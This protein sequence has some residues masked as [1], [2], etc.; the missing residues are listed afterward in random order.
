MIGE[1]KMKI[2]YV[3][4]ISNTINAFLIPH[5]KM[6]INQGHQVDIACNV[7]RDINRELMDLGCKV[8]NI[9]FQRSPLQK[10]N[11]KAFKKLK[12][13]I[14]D[15][16]Y[17]LI[18]THTPV[19][20][21]C[22][23][24]ACKNLENVKV[25][26]TA[27]GF[28]FYKGAPTKNWLIYYPIERY[29]SKYTDVIITINNEDFERARKK[30][31]ANSVEYIPG[32]GLDISK[33]KENKIDK[34]SIRSKL[35]LPEDSFVVLSVGELNENKNHETIIKALAILNNPKI[36]YVVCG[37]GNRLDYLKK[38]SKDLGVMNQVKLL[39]FRSDI[40]DICKSADVFA[41][42]SFREG[43]GMA[44]LEAMASGLPIITSNVHG[45]IDYSINGVTGFNCKPS[46]VKCFAKSI[47]RLY[48][49]EKL[50][51]NMSKNC[52]NIVEKYGI[53]NSL[54]ALEVIYKKSI[55]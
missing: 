38:L 26:Y 17:D 35:G 3:T 48:K 23:R 11:I 24:L 20:S 16:K 36:Y 2:L 15:K 22:V 5:I 7:K 1:L 43:L 53:K 19:A 9:E 47:D 12:K 21:A 42:P 10:D 28:H 30:L 37:K 13:L 51:E 49:D 41:F 8:Y 18:H 6:L 32:V 54:C 44:A 55:I 29:L 45:I 50:R 4:T 33:F 27:H 46:D 39:G 52:L 25:F 40:A 14:Q 31:K 34:L